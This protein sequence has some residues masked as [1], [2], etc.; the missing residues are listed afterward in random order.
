MTEAT[1]HTSMMVPKVPADM[2]M[3]A[4]IITKG[5]AGRKKKRA[6]TKHQKQ[7]CAGLELSLLYVL[8][9]ITSSMA[10]LVWCTNSS[11][12]GT[13]KSITEAENCD[14][15]LVPSASKTN[16]GLEDGQPILD[17]ICDSTD[18]F[19]TKNKLRINIF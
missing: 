11:S 7:Y 5:I 9:L 16:S 6:M 10:P 3:S 14:P 4:I 1:R 18:I 2:R 13:S 12:C 19:R 17:N 15:T 8:L